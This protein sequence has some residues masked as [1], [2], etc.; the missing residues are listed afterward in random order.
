MTI[1]S[2]AGA[3]GGGIIAAAVVVLVFQ[4]LDDGSPLDFFASH[5]HTSALMSHAKK[6]SCAMEAGTQCF[7]GDWDSML[8]N[9]TAVG[10]V[11]HNVSALSFARRHV[12]QGVA[13]QVVGCVR[14]DLPKSPSPAARGDS[15]AAL[16]QRHIDEAFVRMFV[17]ALSGC[18]GDLRD[19]TLA[20]NGE[21]LDV[22]EEEE[23]DGYDEDA[24]DEE[25]EEDEEGEEAEP[26]HSVAGILSY[27]RSRV[28]QHVAA[29]GAAHGMVH[30]PDRHPGPQH[31]RRRKR[32]PH[33]RPAHPHLR[34]A[35]PAPHGIVGNA[36]RKLE[37]VVAG[38]EA[39]LVRA[40]RAR[41]LL[42]RGSNVPDRATHATGSV[43]DA[44]VLVA[45]DTGGVVRR[46]LYWDAPQHHLRAHGGGLGRGLLSGWGGAGVPASHAGQR[47]ELEDDEDDED[48]EVYMEGRGEE[49]D[50]EEGRE[51]GTMPIEDFLDEFSQWQPGKQPIEMQISGPGWRRCMRRF[52]WRLHKHEVCA[53]GK[54]S[55]PCALPPPRCRLPCASRR[56]RS[57]RT[58]AHDRCAFGCIVW[59]L[60][61]A[62]L[63]RW[64]NGFS[65]VHLYTHNTKPD[66][67]TS[68]D[69]PHAPGPGQFMLQAQGTTEWFVA[70]P[71]A[72]T[73][74]VAVITAT[75]SD[76]VYLPKGWSVAA[77]CA[78]ARCVTVAV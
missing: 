21:E 9:G 34:R 28:E 42:E 48:D 1:A 24:Y 49:E 4:T 43:V 23:E 39:R 3:I 75:A 29:H 69:A 20:V 6:C 65:S 57:S 47:V 35:S 66:F 8:T 73:G 53:L 2:R 11:P 67:T 15:K 61:G 76:V 17:S 19:V 18:D 72:D 13:A 12:C 37:E 62:D 71:T 27:A 38:E 59:T 41:L 74:K 70:P 60:T 16:M 25:D 30:K 52:V 78:T 56:G 54:I 36:W 55:A 22:G 68:Y 14:P 63:V 10:V 5:W 50:E 77:R 58:S 64:G 7:G 44:E 51:L 31:R 40:E 46:V 45:A 33:R 26:Q 32:K